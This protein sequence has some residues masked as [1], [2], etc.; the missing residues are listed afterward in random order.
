MPTHAME[1]NGIYVFQQ[2]QAY[3]LYTPQG[4]LIAQLWMGN[5]GQLANDVMT[6]GPICKALSKRWGVSKKAT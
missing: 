6:L 3:S 5:D 1:V 2:G 4:I